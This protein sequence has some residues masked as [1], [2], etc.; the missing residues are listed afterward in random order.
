MRGSSALMSD[1]KDPPC[2]LSA[3]AQPAGRSHPLEEQSLSELAAPPPAAGDPQSC[4][5][6]R[7]ALALSK[8]QGM[9]GQCPMVP[10]CHSNALLNKR[11][12]KDGSSSGVPPLKT[13]MEGPSHC[14]STSSR[15]CYSTESLHRAAISDPGL[16]GG[17]NMRVE[18]DF[19][20][21]C[22][23]TSSTAKVLHPW[24]GSSK[25]DP[26]LCA[27][28]LNVVTPWKL[29]GKDPPAPQMSE[30]VTQR[31]QLCRRR[32]LPNLLVLLPSTWEAVKRAES[33]TAVSPSPKDRSARKGPAEGMSES[34]QSPVCQ[35]DS[36]MLKEFKRIMQNEMECVSRAKTQQHEDPS[37]ESPCRGYSG[38][39]SGCGTLDAGPTSGVCWTESKDNMAVPI[40]FSP[41]PR[42]QETQVGDSAQSTHTEP[43]CLTR[44]PLWGSLEA[45]PSC[46]PSLLLDSTDLSRYGAKIS[47]IKD[48]FIGSALDLIKKS[49]TAE[50]AAE[51]SAWQSRDQ[52]GT[53][54]TGSR[55]DCQSDVV[56]MTTSA[57]SAEAR[58]EPGGGAM[59]ARCRS[60]VACRRSSSDAATQPAESVRGQR[61]R[62]LRPHLSDPMP[63]DATKRKELEIKIAAASFPSQRSV[64]AGESMPE[65]EGQLRKK[66]GRLDLANVPQLR[67]S[68][69][70][71]RSSNRKVVG[72]ADECEGDMESQ[73][74]DISST[75]AQKRASAS[76]L[77]WE[78]QQPC[79]DCGQCEPTQSN[80]MCDKC[81]KR[82][83]ERKEAILELLNTECS[84][85]EDLRII[86]EEFYNPM[87]SAS[88]LTTDQLSVVFG[89]VQELI[90][91]NEKFTER[92]QHSIDQAFDQ[93]DEDLLT[94]CI[95]DIF[96]EFV[97]MLPAF[98]T[99]CLQQST[100][101]NMLNTLEKEKELLRIFLDASQNDNTALRRMNLRSF[102]IAPL[103]RVTK[104]PLLLSRIGKATTKNHPDHT[105]LQEAKSHVES[106]LEHINMK[107]RQEG[108]NWSLR[109]FRRD[110]RRNRE[111][112][113]VEMREVSL[114]V[115]GWTRE[116]TRFVMEGPLQL[117][118]PTDGQWVKKG[119]RALK[120]QNVQSLLMVY[121][122]RVSEG[123][124]ESGDPLELVRDGVLVLIKDKS[125]GKF[126]VLR[127]P[128]RLS[129]C[130][131][132][133][134]PD[135]DDTFE[136]LE[137]PREAFVFRA[138]DKARTQQWFRQIKRYSCDLGP[139]RKR[140]NALPNIMTNTAQNRS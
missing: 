55:P 136:L 83:M 17:P 91:V 88:L 96:L 43:S 87:Q 116:S 23:T 7:D 54:I 73:H 82:R 22:S 124:L 89:N 131:V 32:S 46:C 80:S 86:Y 129:K 51:A 135:C 84:Y 9:P 41:S 69:L 64:K 114:K 94:V 19:V 13:P 21:H 140:R 33:G 81:S 34:E 100:S 139:W 4:L 30:Q 99:Y 57:C 60:A 132:S 111:A 59:S 102:L 58:S 117:S 67:W 26:G 5:P 133:V 20:L 40:C 27:P 3:V 122:P 31:G 10:R 53:T 125:G 93:G 25:Q 28:F 35:L 15:L 65:V 24:W 47:K 70:S 56:S 42:P 137:I 63:A 128:I 123:A 50:L 76:L 103:Q 52:E 120:F 101:V 11:G 134:N 119:S 16:L 95:G 71:N 14:V 127:E 39:G 66:P 1:V 118:Q 68:N 130:V 126:A 104:Y 8:C 105:R 110:S 98:Q 45:T 72:L 109:S 78:V 44:H 75:Y 62:R 138:A 6:S 92:L 106:H 77:T 48:G 107:T 29:Y 113:N 2:D 18:G 38:S 108:T 61:G 97:S 90:S 121:T 36:P 49:C 12:L 74:T 37:R 115:V 79:S 112:P 85:G